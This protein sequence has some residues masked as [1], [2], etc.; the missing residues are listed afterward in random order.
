[1]R[2]AAVPTVPGLSRKWLWW[3][4]VTAIVLC[5]T[6]PSS[7]APPELARWFPT[8]GQRG[9]TLELKAEGTLPD[10]PISAVASDPRI[11]L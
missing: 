9:T 5:S 6:V 11:A 4:V 3:Q 1:M 2:S 10:W 7:A 8:G